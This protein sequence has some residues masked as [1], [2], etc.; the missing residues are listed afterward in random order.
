MRRFICLLVPLIFMCSPASAADIRNIELTDG[1][2]VTGEIV[3][4]SNGIYTIKTESLGI[5]HISSAG[6]R[7]I[8]SKPAQPGTETGPGASSPYNPK[9]TSGVKDLQQ[10]M[11]NDPALL[12]LIM[13]LQDD[14]EFKQA[15]QDPEILEAIKTGDT[16]KL[17][18]NPV[19]Q[20]LLNNPA[21]L[22]IYKKVK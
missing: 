8:T 17:G 4:F 19:I 18:S 12:K 14:P 2:V 15:L 1:S 21:L 13:A 11:L 16:G 7:A 22:E 6:I 3:S 9:F 20:Q 5:L 10:R